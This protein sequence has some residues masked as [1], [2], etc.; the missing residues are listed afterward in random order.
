MINQPDH[1]F[2]VISLGDAIN[3]LSVFGNGDLGEGMEAI[4]KQFEIAEKYGNGD[5]FQKNWPIEISAYNKVSSSVC[6]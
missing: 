3:T 1:L 2:Y 5:T 6:G 4:L